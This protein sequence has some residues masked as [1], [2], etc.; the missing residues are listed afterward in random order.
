MRSESFEGQIIGE[1]PNR[2][3]MEDILLRLEERLRRLEDENKELKEQM[4]Q[5]KE[6]STERERS[7]Q[8]GP[9]RPELG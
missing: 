1:P 7:G 3:D 9:Q 5:S 8:S 4:Q 2:P 6:E